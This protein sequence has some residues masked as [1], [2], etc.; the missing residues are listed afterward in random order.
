M[1]RPGPLRWLRYAFG[2][3]LPPE[4]SEWVLHDTTTP[5]WLLR[6]SARFLLNLSPLIAAILIFLPGPIGLRIGCV[7]VGIAASV[8]LSFGWVVEIADRRAVKAGYPGGLAER[9]R[10]RRGE[11]AQREMAAR[12]RA[13]TAARRGVR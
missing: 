7:A 10:T 4:Y 6:H 3:G 2:G 8:A 13:R 9:T 12:R 11:D 5:T 1:K